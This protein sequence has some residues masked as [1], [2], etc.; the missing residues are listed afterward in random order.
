MDRLRIKILHF[1]ALKDVTTR[2]AG[3]D[4][5]HVAAIR[6]EQKVQPQLYPTEE[7]YYVSRMQSKVSPCN[8]KEEFT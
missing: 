1:V 6:Q 7:I 4:Q 2:T 3:S 5:P 8:K